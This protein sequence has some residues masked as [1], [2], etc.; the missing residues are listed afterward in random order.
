[1]AIVK[2]RV[3]TFHINDPDEIESSRDLDHGRGSDREWLQRHMFWAL[4]N[5]RGVEISPVVSEQ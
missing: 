3:D 4:R 2:I 1:M 5:D